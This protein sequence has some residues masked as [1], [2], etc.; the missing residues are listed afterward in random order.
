MNKTTILAFSGKKQSGKNTCANFIYSKY[1]AR[2]NICKRISIND[3]GEIEV[4]D[5]YGKPEYAGVFNPSKRENQDFIISKVFNELDPHIKLYSFA[6]PLKQD[7]CINVLGLTYN[8]CYGSDK[9]KNE[10]VDCLWPNTNNRMT[11]REVMQYIGTDIFRAIKKDVWT[12]A[13]ISKIN[14]DQSS[15][16]IITDCRFPNE[17]E[18]IK[19]N[20]GYAIRLTRSPYESE[21]ISE[22]VLDKEN[23]NWDNFDY[24]L[25]NQKLNIYEQSIQIDNIIKEVLS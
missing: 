19:E 24:V 16:A 2:L 12:S 17:V 9:Y 5:L 18:C 23:Y 1:L 10:F 6:D 8:Q 3:N 20:N 11:A 7:V 21:H 13:I 14:K 25:D 4:S 22:T 15:L